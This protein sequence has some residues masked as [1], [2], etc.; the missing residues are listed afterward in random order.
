[1]ADANE[2][3]IHITPVEEKKFEIRPYPIDTIIDDRIEAIK[4]KQ[5]LLTK[6]ILST[7]GSAIQ[8]I[9]D[10]TEE[11]IEIALKQNPVAIQYIMKGPMLKLDQQKNKALWIEAVKMEYDPCKDHPINHFLKLYKDNYWETDEDKADILKAYISAN[12]NYLE[13][14]EDAVNKN[15]LHIE[16]WKSMLIIAAAHYDYHIFS[17]CMYQSEL[18]RYALDIS[19]KY[20]EHANVSVTT[21]DDLI[22]Y[23]IE[24]PYEA[25]DMID[26]LTTKNPFEVYKDI[27]DTCEDAYLAH[28]MA[29]AMPKNNFTVDNV[30]ILLESKHWMWFLDSW[31]H[32]FL[33]RDVILYVFDKF[34]PKD[35]IDNIGEPVLK[36]YVNMLPFFRRLKWRRMMKACKKENKR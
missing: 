20:F 33:N 11:E 3:K 2:G 32:C 26:R 31:C 29:D 19:Y 12:P 22:H 24:V 36:H 10:P 23:I 6:M 34:K 14:I 21:Y 25:V 16:L 9:E 5:D 7:N 15:D 4:Q 8:F 1:M 30:A 13:V 35:L 28:L 17:R 18:I 27:F